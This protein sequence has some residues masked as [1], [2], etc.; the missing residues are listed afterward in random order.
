[1]PD[2]RRAGVLNNMAGMALG[3]V[4]GCAFPPSQLPAFL[5]EHVTTLLPSFWFA[6]TARNLQSGSGDVLWGFVLFKLM[7]CSVMLAALAA[8]LF[9]R[10]F[11]AGLQT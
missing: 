9:R 8:W 11:K 6:D 3:L 10:K 5:R 1:V 2:E 4:G 7:L